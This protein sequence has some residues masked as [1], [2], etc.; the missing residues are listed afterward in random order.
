MAVLGFTDLKNT[1]L[2]TL[3][4]T[5]EMEKVRLADGSSFEELIENL[6]AALVA[7]NSSLLTM[8]H[9]SGLYGVQ[10]EPQLEY[11]IGTSNGF[12]EASEYTPPDPRRAKTYGHMLPSKPYDRGLGWTMMALRKLRAIQLQADIDSVV[13]DANKLW[14]QKLLTRFF[15]DTAN[16]VADTALA[17][18]PFANST[19][20]VS[21]YI[22]P[23]SPDGEEFANTHDHF[24]GYGTT[25]I[26][27]DTIDQSAVDVALEHLQEHGYDSPFDL[28]GSRTDVSSWT[29]TTNVTGWKAPEWAGIQYHASAVERMGEPNIG[30]YYGYIESDYGLV[31][32]WLTPRVPT[33]HFGVYQAVGQVDDRNALRVRIHPNIGFGFQVVSGNFVNAPGLMVVVYSEFGVGVANRVGGVCVDVAASTYSAP[34]IS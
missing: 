24:L 18:L 19:N 30:K 3:W 23:P 10:D 28:V 17:D 34:T 11:A 15:S 20:D 1:A 22:P 6:R 27:Q 14:Q 13:I 21:G 5:G 7:V 12:E 8:P 32:V 16:T 29:N 31:R 4:D 25:G 33:K 9:Y 26:T 2:P